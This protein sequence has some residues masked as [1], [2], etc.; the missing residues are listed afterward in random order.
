MHEKSLNT[1]NG[2][3]ELPKL[4]GQ[5]EESCLFLV[6]RNNSLVFHLVLELYLVHHGMMSSIRTKRNECGNGNEPETRCPEKKNRRER[7]RG[8]TDVLC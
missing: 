2:D 3:T 5:C 1:V 4:W 8:T 6:L 7:P